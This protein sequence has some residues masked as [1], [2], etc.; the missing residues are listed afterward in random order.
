[1]INRAELCTVGLEITPKIVDAFTGEGKAARSLR[2][3][4]LVFRGKK[5]HC[6][7]INHKENTR[8]NSKD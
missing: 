6:K 1:M 4:R 5:S 2:D 3:N 8:V 7:K